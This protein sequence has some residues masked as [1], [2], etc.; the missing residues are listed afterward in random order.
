LL[1]FESFARTVTQQTYEDIAHGVIDL[2]FA[3][4]VT[5]ED[6]FGES[7]TITCTGLLDPKTGRFLLGDVDPRKAKHTN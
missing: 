6:I 3:G 5:Y 1:T 7:H 2:K 4:I